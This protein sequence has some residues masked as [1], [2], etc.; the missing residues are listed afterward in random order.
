M[1]IS[2]TAVH[3]QCRDFSKDMRQTNAPRCGFVVLKNS[4]DFWRGDSRIFA[5][6]ILI[7]QLLCTYHS[8]QTHTGVQVSRSSVGHRV[9]PLPRLVLREAPRKQRRRKIGEK[10]LRKTPGKKCCEPRGEVNARAS[11]FQPEVRSTYG[12]MV[13]W[14]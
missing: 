13:A 7:S 6:M 11:S 9:L 4:V 5:G 14:L 2:E 1:S 12:E 10:H 8:F 3:A